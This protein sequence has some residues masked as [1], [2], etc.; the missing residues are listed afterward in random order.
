[1]GRTPAVADDRRDQILAAALAVFAEKGFDR[2]TNR[3]IARAAGITPGL[4]YHY[5]KSK[6]DVLLEAIERHAPLKSLRSLGPASRDMP[7]EELLRQLAGDVL[8]ALED[9]RAVAVL[10][11]LLPEALHQGKPVP[12]VVSALEE[13][14]VLLEAQLQTRMEKGE[15]RKADPVLASRL[16]VGGLVDIAVRRQVLHDPSLTRYTREQIIETAVTTLVLG[17]LPRPGR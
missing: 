7:A 6:K 12:I 2:A 5:F 17:L 16:F 9:E 10:K 13:A 8:E 11:V 3:D 14:A 4:I 1:M 15:L